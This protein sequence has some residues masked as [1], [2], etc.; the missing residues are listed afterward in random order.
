MRSLW[1]GSI[2]FG[3]VNIPIKLYS[4]IESGSLGLD[5]LDKKD[6]SNIQFKRVNEKTGKEVPWENIVK[7]YKID[8]NYVIL[9]DED[10][11]K[12]SPEKTKAIDITEFVKAEEVPPIYYD[13]SYYIEPEK[14]GAK[15]YV[16]L[17]D[18]LIK[19][20]KAA[21]GSF[22]LRNKEN[23]CLISPSKKILVLHKIRYADEIRSTED[24]KVP[25]SKISTAEVQMAMKLIDQLTDKFDISKFKDTYTDTLLK[26]IK[27]KA[28]G[29]KFTASKMRVVHSDKKDL[30]EELKASLS[31]IK[32]KAS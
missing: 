1:T 6:H 12:A 15:A 9:S 18:S 24:I 5:M 20:K 10:F 29:K 22:V 26:F 28:K 7:G 8:S 13:S 27:A 11:K 31:H 16:L 25:E 17:R 23:L 21:I 32:R 3:L 30:M 19:S 4:S 2:S 14:N